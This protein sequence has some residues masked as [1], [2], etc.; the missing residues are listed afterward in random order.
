MHQLAEILVLSYVGTVAAIDSLRH[1]IPNALTVSAAAV[2][3]TLGTMMHGLDGLLAATEGLLVGFL[4]ILPRYLLGGFGAGD[5]KA[6]AAAGSFLGPLGAI[7]AAVCTVIAGGIG[8]LL[9]LIAAG[10]FPALRSMLRRWTF[11]GYVLCTT[12]RGAGLQADPDDVAS[13]RFPYGIAI[14]CGVAAMLLF[15]G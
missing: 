5:V 8:G 1:R 3:L 7:G 10:G 2:G 14:A 12:G 13:R 11:R 4:V 9:V 15:K 6:I